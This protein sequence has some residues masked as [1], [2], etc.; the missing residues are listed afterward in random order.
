MPAD[1]VDQHLAAVRAGTQPAVVTDALPPARMELTFAAVQHGFI[2]NA[3]Q[4]ALELSGVGALGLAK[5]PP[6]IWAFHDMADSIVDYRALLLFTARA[7]EL[8]GAEVRLKETY[9]PDGEHGVGNE[10]HME[11]GWVKEGLDWISQYWS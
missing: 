7:R 6:P 4:G 10:L 1:F 11:E 9:V 3:M 2:V 8:H 5:A